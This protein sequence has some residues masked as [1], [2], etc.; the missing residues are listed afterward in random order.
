MNNLTDVV[1]HWVQSKVNDAVA[2]H[3][4]R[5]TYLEG[6][7]STL[8][9]RLDKLEKAYPDFPGLSSHV[10]H[11]SEHVSTVSQRLLKLEKAYPD[12]A[13]T[14]DLQKDTR[15]EVLMDKLQPLIEQLIRNELEG[16]VKHCDLEEDV[17]AI[18]SELSQPDD[19]DKRDAQRYRWLR[20]QHWSDGG[21][22]VV[23]YSEQNIKLGTQ[24]YRERMLDEVIDK[25][26]QK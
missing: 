12:M 4:C 17:A 26:L 25:E 2:G 8:S 22:I 18:L 6:F 13:T 11:M 3:S 24:C 7:V 1:E 19:A 5:I 14:K 9:E 21:F 20:R 10:E 15:P 23:Q 16:C